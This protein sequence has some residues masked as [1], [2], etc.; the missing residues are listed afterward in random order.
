MCDFASHQSKGFFFI[1]FPVRR[2]DCAFITM[3]PSRFVKTGGC[4][5]CK[6]RR[7]KCDEARPICGNCNGLVLDCVYGAKPAWM[8]G[9]DRQKHKASSLKTEVKRNVARNRG[10]AQ[11]R[12]DAFMDSQKAGYTVISDIA[13]DSSL[14]PN[15]APT[16]SIANTPEGTDE[17]N[18]DEELALIA[19]LPWSHQQERR[20]DTLE[21]ASASEWNFVMKYLDHAFPALFPFYRPHVFDTGRNWIL[22]LLRKSRIAYHA[23][24][25]ISCYYFTLTLS[26]AEGEAEHAVCKQLRWNEVDKETGLCFS[27]L[28]SEIAA[29]NLHVGNT[30]VTILERAELFSSITQVIVFEMALGKSAPWDTHL[31]AAITLFEEIMASSEARSTY[32]GQPQSKL[33]SVLLGFEDP[34]WTNSSPSNHIWSAS[35]TGFR[36]CT[37]LL[38]FVDIIAS[39]SLGKAPQLLRYHSDVLAKSDDGL[40]A[41][42]EAEIRLSG[43]VGCYNCIAESIAEISSLSSWKSALR[44]DMQNTQGTQRFHNVTLVLEN[45][46]HDIQQ[47]LVVKATSSNSTAPALIWGFAADIYRVVAVEGWQLANPSIRANVA[48]ITKLLDSVPSNQLR[49]IAW[50]ICIAGCF[51]EKHEESFFS[52]LFLRSRGA[53]SFGALRDAQGLVEKAWLS[54]DEI[55]ERSFDLASGLA[56]LGPR[57]LL[58]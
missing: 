34:M 14:L 56:T 37:G 58:V 25:G 52:A 53:E 29:L 30:P 41:V 15:P 35:Q 42:G 16:E 26:D 45:S 27:S 2:S 18:L 43:I 1:P 33:A 13:I 19:T 57:I 28:R 39:T 12:N 44:S 6:L 9:G 8:D 49:T 20:S 4:W 50:P 10:R 48:Q 54:R 21:Q 40:P 36:F 47:K 24:L 31:P 3:P 46:L 51:A 23:A 55:R 22:L 32:R 38:I 5:T 7:K 17:T 11:G